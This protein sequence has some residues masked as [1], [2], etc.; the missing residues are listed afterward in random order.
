M[1]DLV[2]GLVLAFLLCGACA[3]SDRSDD[4]DAATSGAPSLCHCA[5][6]ALTL[7]CCDGTYASIGVSCVNGQCISSEPC[8]GRGGIRSSFVDDSGHSVSSCG[9]LS[10]TPAPGDAGAASNGR[11]D[12]GAGAASNGRTD[13]GA[14]GGGAGAR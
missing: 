6:S 3:S 7:L 8:L 10:D 14:G 13:G 4:N 12:G 1:G 11:A 9:T 2:A 5:T